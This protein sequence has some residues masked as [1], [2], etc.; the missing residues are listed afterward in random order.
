M[1]SFDPVSAATHLGMAAWTAFAGLLAWRLT[2]GH[3]MARRTSVALYGLS[4]VLLYAASGTFHGLMAAYATADRTRA[5]LMEVMWVAQR[6]DKT[7]IFLLIL[8][9]NLPVQMYLLRGWWRSVSV[10]GM[11]LF[12]VVGIV[13]MWVWPGMPHPA[14]VAVYV[15][16]GIFGLVPFRQYL[17]SIG[18]SGMAWILAFA[19]VYIGGAVADVAKWPT[20]VPGVF[21]PHELLHVCDMVATLIHYGFLLRFVIAPAVEAGG[22]P[23]IARS[24]HESGFVFASASG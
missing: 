14:L 2:S 10:I 23:P 1:D 6:L 8:G 9:S 7:A 13:A 22:T 19:A 18:W 12:A 4:A 3:G 5:E 17:P 15:G 24:S 16:M 21:G 20:L 11:T